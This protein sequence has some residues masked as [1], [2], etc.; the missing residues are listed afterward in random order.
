VI[1]VAK[2]KGNL[3]FNK[4]LGEVIDMMK[5][6][7]TLQF[8]QF[9]SRQELSVD[10]LTS[11]EAAFNVAVSRQRGKIPFLNPKPGL[12]SGVILISSDEG[13]LGELNSLLF[14]KFMDVKQSQDRLV[15]LG[16]QG[17]DYL[18]EMGLHCIALPSLDE[19]LNFASAQKL[20]D[21]V[22]QPYINGEIGRVQIIYA[23]FINIAL[24]Q[25]ESDTLL[26]L[27]EPSSVLPASHE[28]F[29]I[30][31]DVNEVVGGWVKLWLGFRLFQIMWSSK[32]AEFGA[33]IMHLEGS[34]QELTRVNHNLKLEYFKYL[35]S[36]SDKTIREISA[37]RLQRKH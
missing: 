6:A 11:L 26:P 31:P 7:A 30:E 5:M 16:R 10:Y 3:D 32:L 20:R 2:L 37:S 29:I 8:N 17:A 23:R 34:I 25:V 22:L 18:E 19:K 36:L 14:N 13:F 4:N 12:P 35:H 28:E 21:E 27:P 9:R 33:R 1:P 24:Q 15:V